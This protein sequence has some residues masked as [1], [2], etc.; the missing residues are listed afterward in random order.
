MR[1]A[2]HFRSQAIDLD[3]AG[4]QLFVWGGF[5]SPPT[6]F[7]GV[8][9]SKHHMGL[10][11]CSED[12]YSYLVNPALMSMLAF[13]FPRLTVTCCPFNPYTCICSDSHTRSIRFA[14]YAQNSCTMSTSEYYL[15]REALH[16]NKISNHP[17]G[18]CGSA[19][20]SL[21]LYGYPS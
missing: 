2:Q 12:F 4:A 10:C 15:N 11:F 6:D 8:F 9:L 20:S 14:S 1:T 5:F 17:H 18:S 16:R 7:Y 19:V 21:Q 3:K 13:A